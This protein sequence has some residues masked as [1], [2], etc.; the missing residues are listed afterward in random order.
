MASAGSIYIDILLNDARYKDGL[1]KAG[2]YA[3][4]F[5]KTAATA[6][7]GATVAAGALGTAIYALSTRKFP[8]IN[9]IGI[10]ARN[11]GIATEE[12]QALSRAIGFSNAELSSLIDQSQK[13]TFSAAS[14]AKRFTDTFNR[15]G[16]DVKEL[17]RL[18]PQEQFTKIAESISKISDPVIRNTS[19]IAIF[20]QSIS[21]SVNELDNLSKKLDEARSFQDKFG[22][23]LSN[24]DTLKVKEAEDSLFKVGDAIQGLFT[25]L[26]IDV[27]P[28]ITYIANLFLESG[29]TAE[30]FG[31]AV[32]KAASISGMALDILRRSVSGV[33]I[34]FSSLVFTIGDLTARL[35]G[36]LYDLGQEIASTLNLIPGVSIQAEESL[37]DIGLAARN[38]ATD[39]SASIRQTIEDLNNF[40]TTAE[41]VARIQEEANRRLSGAQSPER[42]NNVAI[43]NYSR[44]TQ[45]IEKFLIKQREALETLRQEADYIGLTSIE[46]TKLRDAR[47][48][49]AQIAERSYGLKGRELERFREQAEAIKNLRQEVL[50]YNYDVSRSAQAGLE[51][52]ISKYTEDATNSAQNIQN[53]LQNAF[54]GAEDAFVEFTK[55]GKLNFRDLANSIIEDL[56][57]IQFRN[58]VS[59]LL[60]GLG[61]GSGGGIFGSLLSGLGG[62]FGGGSSGVGQSTVIGNSTAGLGT[63][64]KFFADG[65]YLPPGQFGIAG[66]AGAELL[67]GGKTGVSVF[68]Q[69]Q[70]GGR[71]NTYNID[72]RGADQGAVVRLEQAL[73]ALA[74]PGVIEQRV[75]NAQSRGSL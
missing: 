27:A 37:L 2:N 49:E 66:E 24:I 1:S 41:K 56:I 10:L 63:G 12:F 25:R 8:E 71:G 34:T 3:K 21:G 7:A 47:E 73:L 4:G 9:S 45:S 28:V 51:E 75:N 11:A 39:A 17:L 22:I 30:K 59:G 58:S 31:L 26:S 6:I 5:G 65:G 29:I 68:N 35:S 55:T 61:G 16:I 60:G 19:A 69:D 40:E 15:L 53:V 67:Y 44:Q 70:I 23:S 14:G 36:F 52:F 46:I 74:G 38:M 54:K 72:A 42:T 20:G 33:S 57:R 62:I 48:L 32:Q 13:S 43:E 64:I 18:N 50:Q